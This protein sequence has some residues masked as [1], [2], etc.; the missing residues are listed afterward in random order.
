ML[1]RSYLLKAIYFFSILL[2]GIY[3]FKKPFYNWDLLP[4]TALVLKMDHYNAKQAHDLAYQFAKENIPAKNFQQLTD[5]THSYRNSMYNDAEAFNGQLPFY[6]VKPLYT[7]LIYLF[8]KSGIDLPHATLFPSLLAYLL[9]GLLLFHWLSRYLSQVAT[10]IV[11]LLVMISPPLIEVAKTSSPDCLS[12]F[13]LFASFYFIIEKPFLKIAFVF[14]MISVFVRLDNILTCLLILSVIFFSK[15]WDRKISF[16]NFFFMILSLLAV[17]IFI[18]SM[19]NQYGWSIFFYNN[20]ASRL[21]PVYG[22][23][24][25]FSLKSYGRVMYEHLLNGIKHSYI[26]IFMTLLVLIF[27]KVSNLKNISF[28]HLFALLIPLILLLRFI[29]YPDIS[30]RF[31]IAFYL[32]IIILLTKKITAPSLC[33]SAHAD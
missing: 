23:G 29:L 5:S 7:T 13:C 33:T 4:Y 32:I 20:F 24:E 31:Y 26:T 6:V 22:S 18:S 3:C 28:N 19:A 12:A 10:C 30:D 25:H 9:I 2:I 15:R 8:Y 11:A 27:S 17:Y 14:M 16:S 1:K 21:H